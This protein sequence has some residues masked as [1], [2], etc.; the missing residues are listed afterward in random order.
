MVIGFLRRRSSF[1]LTFPGLGRMALGEGEEK[2]KAYS[3]KIG[4]MRLSIFISNLVIS[5]CFLVSLGHGVRESRYCL[6]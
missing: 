4:E 3:S 6:R 2:K 1:P 5:K